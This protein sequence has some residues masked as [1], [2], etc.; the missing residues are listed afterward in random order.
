MGNHEVRCTLDSI[1]Y[2]SEN[3]IILVTFPPYCSHLLQPLEAG[4]MGLFKGKLCLAQH[5]WMSANPGK[6]TTIHDLE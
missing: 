2:A 5:N 6:V 1:L 4:V 3:G